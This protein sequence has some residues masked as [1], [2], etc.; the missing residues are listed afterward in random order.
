MEE[1]VDMILVHPVNWGI[2]AK[3][4]RDQLSATSDSREDPALKIINLGPGA[5]L[6]RVTARAMTGLKVTVLDRSVSGN[7]AT[8]ALEAPILP[9]ANNNSSLPREHIAIVGMAVNLPGAPDS[10]ALWRLLE[11]GLN[12]ISEVSRLGFISQ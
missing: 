10:A 1:I 8:G 4:V 2:V 5:G 7:A 11:D 3:S 9:P 12:T 6:G